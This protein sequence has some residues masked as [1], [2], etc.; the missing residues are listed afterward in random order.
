MTNLSPLGIWDWKP[1]VNDKSPNAP[2]V[3]KEKV[4]MAFA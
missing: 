4:T 3:L 1:A 2:E